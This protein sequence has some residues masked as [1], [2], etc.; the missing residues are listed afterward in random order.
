[1]DR[2][3]MMQRQKSLQLTNC[4]VCYRIALPLRREGRK[5]GSEGGKEVKECGSESLEESNWK[6]NEEQKC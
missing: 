6:R 1:M 3:I 5:E 4:I 2:P